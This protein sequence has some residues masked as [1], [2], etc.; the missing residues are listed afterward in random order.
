VA[1]AQRHRKTIMNSNPFSRLSRSSRT[2]A[3]LLLAVGAAAAMALQVF[4]PP[5]ERSAHQS[6]V[7]PVGAPAMPASS[8]GPVIDHSVVERDDLPPE[9]DP[10][11]LAVA[12]YGS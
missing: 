1:A 9:P 8:E 6:L 3:V 5:V 7:Q 12:A 2:V 4:M 11:P 10:S